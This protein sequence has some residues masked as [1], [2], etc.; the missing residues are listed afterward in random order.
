MKNLKSS[1]LSNLKACFSLFRIKTAEG[2]T[3][4]MAGLAGAST[5][6]FWALIEITVYIIFYNYASNKTAGLTAGISLKQVVTYTWLAQLFFLMQP[7]NI[8]SDILDKI[9]SGDV[10]IELCRPLDLYF[11]WFSKIAAGRITPMLW[12]GSITIA[13]GILMPGIYKIS[14]PSSFS[15]FLCMLISLLS[16]FLVCTSYGM[17]ACVV[18]LNVPWGNGPTY[19]M[20]LVGSILSG[21]YLPLQLW[22]NALQHFLLL[23]PFA[24]YLDIPVRF[25]IGT[26][27]PSNALVPIVTQLVW[28]ILFVTLGRLLI[29]S[30]LKNIVV[31]G[32]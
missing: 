29:N 17:L 28:V 9:T 27:K 30:R 14:L 3:Y 20:M 32:G 25:Y 4:R 1:F 15:G 23:Q 8:D 22:P 13:A 16:A 2:T 18:R 21:A 24:G 6:I 7:M 26:L 11:H 19:M 5:S 10:G 31:Q 12:R